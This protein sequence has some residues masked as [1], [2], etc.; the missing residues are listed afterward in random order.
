[1]GNGVPNQGHFGHYE[2]GV[3]VDYR[4]VYHDQMVTGSD[5]KPSLGITPAAYADLHTAA[6]SGQT[7]FETELATTA[8]HSFF[9]VYAVSKTALR[10]GVIRLA[11]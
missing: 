2:D 10:A 11:P 8:W 9:G 4:I 6:Q 5:W 3:L 1:M 7:A